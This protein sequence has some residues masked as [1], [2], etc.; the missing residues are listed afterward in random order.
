MV[1]QTRVTVAEVERELE[2][3]YFKNTLH[4]ISTDQMWSV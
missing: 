3:L 2:L 1:A 4:R